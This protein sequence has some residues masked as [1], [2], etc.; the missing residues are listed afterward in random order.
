MADSGMGCRNAG[1]T[2]VTFPHHLAFRHVKLWIVV[3][4]VLQ[5]CLTSEQAWAGPIARVDAADPLSQSCINPMK[6]DFYTPEQAGMVVDEVRFPNAAGHNLRGW[7]FPNPQASQSILFCMGNTGNISLMLP[8]AQIFQQSGY[9]VLLFDYQGFGESEGV[10]VI[11]S[12]LSDSLAACDFLIAHTGRPADQTGIFGVSL[13]SILALA[14]AAERSLGA[15]AVESVFLPEQEVD[16]F[17]RRIVENNPAAA[18]G[19][20]IAKSLLLGR[21]D[22]VRN[23]SRLTCPVFFMHGVQ[24]RLLRATGSVHV[25]NAMHGP[26]RLWL[27]P[28]TGHAPESL[29]VNDREYESQLRAFFR[30]AFSESFDQVQVRRLVCS[31]P[32]ENQT[33]D[34]TCQLTIPAWPDET[35]VQLCLMDG[36]G[37]TAFRN[38][39]IDP[40]QTVDQGRGTRMTEVQIADLY[41]R[42]TQAYAVRSHHVTTD[43]PFWRS[44]LSPFSAALIEYKR[45]S[46]R[47][48]NGDQAERI[49]TAQHGIHFNRY[50]YLVPR[51]PHRSVT[52]LLQSVEQIESAPPRIQA[53]YARLLARLHCWPEAQL[54]GAASQLRDACGECVMKLLP[55][56]P[57]A[58]Y[59]LRDADLQL[60]FRDVVV[61][62]SLF[63]LAQNRLRDGRIQEARSLLQKYVSVLPSEV[64]TKLTEQQIQSITTPEDLGQ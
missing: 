42:P 14:V 18:L 31:E 28:A 26:K 12:L 23:V 59:E 55:Q 11:G 10:A 37:R 54:D 29:E 43:R 51:F 7:F 61:G 1:C 50:Q 52:E 41:F 27:M 30:E 49:L 36:R 35:P 48:L 20:R 15:V 46:R 24:D 62:E 19:L 21:V 44:D 25:Y 57:D 60:T 40:A 3:G 17:T 22:P 53:R 45:C 16:R 32:S 4:M 8:Y 6:G 38:L 13:G 39:W 63:R 34:V 9:E 58:Y 47:I 33:F 5:C 64:A 2:A 56:D